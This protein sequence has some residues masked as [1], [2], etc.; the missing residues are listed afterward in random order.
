MFTNNGKVTWKGPGKIILN[1]SAQ[2]LNQ[3]ASSFTVQAFPVG[4]ALVDQASGTGYFTVAAGA[5]VTD[6]KGV[7]FNTL[8]T[9]HGTYTLQ[10]AVQMGMWGGTITGT[11]NIPANAQVSFD[12]GAVTV[13]GA[14]MTGSG[15]VVLYAGASGLIVAG[16]G[17][18]ANSDWQ[19]Q[20]VGRRDVERNRISGRGAER[21]VAPRF[22]SSHNKGRMVPHE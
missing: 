1:N 18:Y 22:E 4:L 5:T 13:N 17:R 10:N 16:N 7:L 21:V 6:N 11:V 12:S 19:R 15:L 20:Q 8:L 2:W 14:N 9:M 3:S